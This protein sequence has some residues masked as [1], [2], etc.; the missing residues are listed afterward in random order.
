MKT[1]TVDLYTFDELND[2]AKEKAIEDHR[3]YGLGYSW[4]DFIY[5]DA[6][7][8]GLKIDGF[9]L[10][11]RDITG[12]LTMSMPESISEITKNH[13]KMCDTHK[14]ASIFGVQYALLAND[15]DVQ[16]RIN[17]KGLDAADAMEEVASIPLAREYKQALL[18]EYFMK[19]KTEYEEMT[20]DEGIIESIHCNEYWFTEDGRF[21]PTRGR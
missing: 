15:P 10:Y 9:D 14:M 8:V 2:K 18:H 19:L 11:R 7:L 17:E 20:S 12:E 16:Y 5:E 1:I 6:R 13:G 3:Q 4:W 21:W